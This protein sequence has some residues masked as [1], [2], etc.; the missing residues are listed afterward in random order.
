[1]CM[2]HTSEKNGEREK[3]WDKSIRESDG[4]VAAVSWRCRW[5]L[6]C[7]TPGGPVMDGY[8]DRQPAGI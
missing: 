1:M 6:L 2:Y 5:T 8:F 7:E 4:K 3:E